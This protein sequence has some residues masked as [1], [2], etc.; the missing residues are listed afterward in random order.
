MND[1]RDT[2]GA[3]FPVLP[4]CDMEGVS[5]SGYPYPEAGMSLRD[6]FAA[7]A[8]Q[9]ALVNARLPGVAQREPETM[10]LVSELSA[11]CYVIADAMLKARLA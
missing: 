4:P 7:K 11:C 8:M 6:Y 10:E 9:A 1:D 5:A 3:A 2:G